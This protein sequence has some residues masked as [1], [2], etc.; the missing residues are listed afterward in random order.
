MSGATRLAEFVGASGA[1]LAADVSGRDDAPAVLLLHGGGQTRHSW[2]RAR[3]ELG[4][5]GYRAI[6]LDS[7]GHGDSEWVADGDYSLEAQVADLLAVVRQVGGRPALVGASM[8][9]VHS[10][11]ACGQHATPASALVLVDVTPRL[12]ANGV[13]HIVGFMKGHLDGFA[14]LE[15]AATAVAAYNPNRPPP[16]D[17]KGLAKNLRQR[18]DGR[19]YWH[20]DP[21]F[22]GGDHRASVAHI[23]Q[24]M[25]A[26]A[27]GV[28]LPTLLVRG[29]LSDVVSYDGVEELKRMLPQLEFVDIQGA[30]H[31]VAGDKNDH[32]NAAI[33]DFL[34]RHYPPR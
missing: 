5:R 32:F 20:W 18:E 26:S 13:E 24:R 21:R 16:T 30:G 28:A 2:A 34:R 23:S 3:Q 6:A 8:G 25:R 9:G 33:L 31:M 15:E 14:S 19:W 17:M 1:R 29:N 4:D 7:R 12:E 11:I 10:L 27:A 22:M